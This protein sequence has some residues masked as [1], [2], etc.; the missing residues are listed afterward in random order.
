MGDAAQQPPLAPPSRRA[1]RA[2][3]AAPDSLCGA[4]VEASLAAQRA[5]GA[6]ELQ[7]QASAKAAHDVE[8]R[9]LYSNRVGEAY[10]AQF[11]TSHR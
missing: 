7:R 5:A 6:V 3:R 2:E 9:R 11:G 4:Q 8:M 1:R 10:F